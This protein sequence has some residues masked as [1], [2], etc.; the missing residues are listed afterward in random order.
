MTVTASHAKV[1]C[2]N[3]YSPVQ[4]EVPATISLLIIS[5]ALFEIQIGVCLNVLFEY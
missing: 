2:L 3:E 1:N 4:I 5:V